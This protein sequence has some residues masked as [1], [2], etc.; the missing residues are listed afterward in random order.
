MEQRGDGE[1]V[2]QFEEK[3]DLRDPS[4]FFNFLDPTL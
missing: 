3:E 4:F 1:R 2:R